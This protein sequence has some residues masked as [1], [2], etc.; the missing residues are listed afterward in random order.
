MLSTESETEIFILF[1]VCLHSLTFIADRNIVLNTKQRL[2]L[3]FMLQTWKRP[4]IEMYKI[5]LFD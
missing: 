5:E 3:S 1:T 4:L 2:K